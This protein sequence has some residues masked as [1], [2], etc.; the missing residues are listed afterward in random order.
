MFSTII[1]NLM[2]K[3]QF[4]K[5]N[6]NLVSQTQITCNAFLQNYIYFAFIKRLQKKQKPNFELLTLNLQLSYGYKQKH[7]HPR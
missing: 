7:P 1:A 3:Y 4:L 2:A 5:S 6:I